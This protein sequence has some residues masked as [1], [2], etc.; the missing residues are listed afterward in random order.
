M[1][2]VSI[3]TPCYNEELHVKELHRAVEEIFDGLEGYDFEHLFIDNA[4]TDHTVERIK[5]L[6]AESPRVKAIVN[7]RNFGHVRSPRHAF[8]QAS[9][10][11][12]VCMAAD[13][14]NPPELLTKF[15]E[16]WEAGSKIVVGVK[17]SSDESR[18]MW[19]IRSAYY[20]LEQRVSDIHLISQF[21]GYGLFDREVVEHLREF[22]EPYPYFRG[23]VAELGYPITKVLYK[24]PPRK[25]G[26]SNNNFYDLFDIAMLGITSYSKVPLRLATMAGFVLS[27]LSLLT[28][29]GY[30]IAK[31][32][33]WDSFSV[34]IAPLIIGV[35]FF[36]SI[37][38]F[39][40]GILGEY[41]GAIHTNTLK[42]PYVIEKERINF[43]ESPD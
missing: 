32:S 41:I 18:L 4:S 28:A 39:F 24:Q 12:V 27:L 22:D 7:T 38:L 26:E 21:N 8:L 40:I 42:R 33:Y 23:Q 36:G 2:L 34:G 35:F 16:H 13:F 29:L 25:H 1:K 43:P 19:W 11:A 20:R 30:L 3:V 5:E 14:Q 10:D 31:L 17:E 9:G 37:Q 15:I 6:A